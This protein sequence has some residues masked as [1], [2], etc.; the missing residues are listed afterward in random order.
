M[1]R[2]VTS[3]IT[4]LPFPFVSDTLNK[5]LVKIAYIQ[6]SHLKSRSGRKA[7]KT[8]S[9]KMASSNSHLT[10]SITEYLLTSSNVT[11]IKKFLILKPSHERLLTL[12]TLK[13]RKMKDSRAPAE[14]LQITYFFFMVV[15]TCQKK[16]KQQQWTV[17][18]KCICFRNY[19]RG[20]TKKN[21]ALFQPCEL[22]G[23]NST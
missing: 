13:T 19:C 20:A 4:C 5:I 3:I 9:V 18:R 16:K 15:I 22:S 12:Q 8:G 10:S 11:N 6:M 14:P 17:W 2:R 1:L 7:I 23:L 21:V